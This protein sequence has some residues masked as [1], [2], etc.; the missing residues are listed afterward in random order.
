M[1]ALEIKMK[2][3]IIKDGPSKK[4]ACLSTTVTMSGNFYGVPRDGKFSEKKFCIIS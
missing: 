2:P 1:E 4:V 3:I